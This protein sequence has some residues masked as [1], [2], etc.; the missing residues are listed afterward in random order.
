MSATGFV[1]ACGFIPASSG[2]GDFVVSSAVQGYQ[3]PASA[4]A[5]NATVYSYRAESADKSQWEEGFGAYTVSSTTLARTT[6]TANS[7][8]GTS[9]I[10]FSAA[11]N[12]Y[13]TAASA[14]LQNASLLNTGT[15]PLAQRGYSMPD[16]IVEEQQ[17][18]GT[19]GGTFTSGAWRTRA[20]NTLVRN[21]NSI[22]SLASNQITLPAGTYYFKYA[23]TAFS[24]DD[25]QAKI[26]NVTDSTDV[27][28]GIASYAR[29]ASA[30]ASNSEGSGVVT[31]TA[32]KT[33]A[34]QHQCA[35][36]AS[37]NGLGVG[38]N[39]GLEVFS[40]LEITRLA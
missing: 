29:A 9:K 26:S 5:V 25:H 22:A 21:A 23:A 38:A 36:T 34:L 11:P 30:G 28:F 31:I 16:V 39:F 8:G 3:T 37:G 2:T 6:V 32:S 20:L 33:F 18:S 24:V 14:D 4:G 40:R 17:A 13:I 27:S 12:V 1:D 15:L 19:N 35:T 7:S 10:A